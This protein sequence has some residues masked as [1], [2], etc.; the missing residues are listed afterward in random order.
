[1]P[2]NALQD[3]FSTFYHKKIKR[4]PDSIWMQVVEFW[5][6]HKT[7][8]AKI[9]GRMS[10]DIVQVSHIVTELEQLEGILTLAQNPK[11]F[12][13]LVKDPNI[14]DEQRQKL[15]EL[16]SDQKA[17][18]NIA[19][20]YLALQQELKRFDINGVSPI[21][22]KT[23]LQYAIV[24]ENY[25]A[26]LGL[27]RVAES[28]RQSL[29]AE[30]TTQNQHLN[31]FMISYTSIDPLAPSLTD[32]TTL[33]YAFLSFIKNSRP[34]LLAQHLESPQSTFNQIMTYLT[35]LYAAM[36]LENPT[37]EQIGDLKVLQKQLLFVLAELKQTYQSSEN[38]VKMYITHLNETAQTYKRSYGKIPEEYKARINRLNH[39]LLYI[40]IIISKIACAEES[41]RA[42]SSLPK[43]Q[44]AYQLLESLI[45]SSLLKENSMTNLILLKHWFSYF[46]ALY[47]E[48]KG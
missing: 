7:E 8:L 13:A 43:I 22:K 30:K 42:T 45:D 4:V 12:E 15:K 6:M 23:P 18:G 27:I 10:Q 26:A 5:P 2:V 25:E 28:L 20:R 29:S 9:S 41:I 3:F 48:K 31:E 36:I 17:L 35:K 14:N 38:Q 47:P 44:I 37:K 33:E 21:Y 39:A 40:Q 34:A 46:C 16:L 24:Q 32:R 19:D 1:M 11:N